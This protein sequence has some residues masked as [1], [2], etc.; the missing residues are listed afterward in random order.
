MRTV[1]PWSFRVDPAR[2]LA[3][4]PSDTCG[5]ELTV[6]VSTII[7]RTD[8]SPPFPRVWLSEVKDRFGSIS[9]IGLATDD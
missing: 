9:L 8:E 5:M 7:L 4:T 6:S 1:P 2:S 3:P